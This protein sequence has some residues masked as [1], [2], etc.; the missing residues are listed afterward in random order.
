M[1]STRIP[2]ADIIT[3]T[4]H[5]VI[6][7]K[8]LQDN[9]LFKPVTWRETADDEAQEKL[10]DMIMK[11]NDLFRSYGLKYIQINMDK[12]MRESYYIFNGHLVFAQ[13]ICKKN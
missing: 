3:A 11:Y 2:T 5:C 12:V 9:S 4:L 1:L 13:M 8:G 6:S 10:N 7:N